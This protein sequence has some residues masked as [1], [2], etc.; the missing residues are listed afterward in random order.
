MVRTSRSAGSGM[1]S[2][3]AGKAEQ[4]AGGHIRRR[5]GARAA[6]A[7]FG[8]AVMCAGAFTFTAGPA[9][10]ASGEQ[11][12]TVPSGT[13]QDFTVPAGVT[14]I[15]IEADGAQGGQNGGL[16][17]HVT[18]DMNV[19]PGQQLDVYV[20]GQGGIIAGGV[21]GGGEGRTT[22]PLSTSTAGG[23]GGASDIRP[24]GGSP[25]GRLLVAA[26]GGGSSGGVLSRAAGGA[27]GADGSNGAN[28]TTVTG[29]Q[30]GGAGTASAGGQGGAAG[31]PPANNG[32]PGLLAAGGNGGNATAGIGGETN[33]GGGGGGGLYG[34]GG[35]AGGS[36]VIVPVS[37]FSGG[38]GGG[39]GSSLDPDG[40]T[41]PAA[42]RAG[43]GQ[44]TISWDAV[45]YSFSGFFAPVDNPPVV[46]EVNAGR[47]VPV[48]FSL[49]GDQGLDIL[50]PNS[51]SSQQV[52]CSSSAPVD[53]VE[54]TSSQ[55]GLTYNPATGEY[56]YNWK[57]QK[58]WSGTCRVF[59]LTLDDGTVHTLNFQFK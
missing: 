16:G 47:T 33:S 37:D 43:D 40:G 15:H 7:V 51:P 17:A 45:T 2:I 49:G 23:G 54:S 32:T 6:G 22:P 28:G 35:G 27:A 24:D 52:A 34:G 30:G 5:H 38:G 58:A 10:A 25:S 14:S 29:G 13:A 46:N 59:N 18:A 57:T 56:Q 50:A 21:N 4:P 55:S 9:S 11:T 53:V 44:V 8:A 36:V 39:G 19:T 31:A 42:A 41:A 12:F 20:G 48:K 1:S 26:G 3:Q